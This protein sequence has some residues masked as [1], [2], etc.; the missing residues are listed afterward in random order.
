M[1]TAKRNDGGKGFF[2]RPILPEKPDPVLD[3]FEDEV[4]ATTVFN[5]AMFMKTPT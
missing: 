1:S 2:E 4:S 5:S 3:S